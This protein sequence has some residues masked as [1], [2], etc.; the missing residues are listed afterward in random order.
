MSPVAGGVFTRG[1]AIHLNGIY[2]WSFIPIN[3]IFIVDT[4]LEK[5]RR[6]YRRKASLEFRLNDISEV[7]WQL[8]TRGEGR[9][10]EGRGRTGE[11]LQQCL[12]WLA[13]Y[14]FNIKYTSKETFRFC[15]SN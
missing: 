9:G 12:K 6:A 3:Q 10:G 4:G 13:P 14:K 2:R 7:K 5:P 1:G 15:L 8:C 11:F